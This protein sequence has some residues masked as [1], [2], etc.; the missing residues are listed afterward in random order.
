L[1][2]QAEELIH[3]VELFR[4]IFVNASIGIAVEGCDGRFAFTNTAFNRMLGYEPGELIGLQ[5]SAV[6]P[7]DD[8]VENEE[9]QRKFMDTDLPDQSYRSVICERMVVLSG[10]R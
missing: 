2:R 5:C 4:N 8:V 9:W 6:T 10:P 1:P 7:Q 3:D